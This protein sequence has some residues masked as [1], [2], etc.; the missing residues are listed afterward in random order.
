MAYRRRFGRIPLRTDIIP[1]RSF[2]VLHPI[3]LLMQLLMAG[4]S[5]ADSIKSTAIA[6]TRFQVVLNSGKQLGP[7]DL[8]GAVLT[9]DLAGVGRRA[10]RINAVTP[11]PRDAA[12]E[13]L[14]YKMS[15]RDPQSGQW[16]E[17]C[18]PDPDGK[19]LAFP[20]QGQWDLTG[21]R[22]SNRGLTLACTDGALA[23]CVRFGYKPWKTLA[24][25][26]SLLPYHEACV[27]LVRADYCGNNSATT[28]TGTP[29]DIF[30][31]LGIQR[32]EPKDAMPFEAAWDVHG[33][34]CVAHPRI[35]QNISLTALAASCPRLR[36]H[37]GPQQCTESTQTAGQAILFNR[38]H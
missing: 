13:V 10:L 19:H 25:G 15:I 2:S 8:L 18:G 17:A 28:R 36:A 6:G 37:L 21:H 12:G 24:D 1:I 35:P 29:I 7:Q 11:D 3:L 27:H 4:F 33:A 23:K 31:N 5:C 30:D 26:R 16:T 9:L 38:S 14:L 20:L 22:V 32:P 34:I